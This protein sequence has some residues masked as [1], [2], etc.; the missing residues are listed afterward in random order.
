[1][2]ANPRWDVIQYG[3][4]SSA[5]VAK[6]LREARESCFTSDG[7]NAKFAILV[8]PGI[9]SGDI[10]MGQYNATQVQDHGF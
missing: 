6:G 5:D 2:S 1:M 9:L 4:Q 3:G 7:A 10:R 8:T